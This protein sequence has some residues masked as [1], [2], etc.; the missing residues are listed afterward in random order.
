MLPVIATLVAL[1]AFAYL[2]QRVMCFVEARRFPPPGILV[3]VG[4]H[5]LHLDI[6]GK[7]GPTVVL[8]S[9]LA[10]SSLSWAEIQPRLAEVTRVVS[11]DRAGFGWSDPPLRPRR[12]DYLVEELRDALMAAGLPP[13]WVLVGH[14]Y[15][16]W[17]AQLFA[18]RYPGEVGSL[19]LVDVPH[20]RRWMTPDPAQKRRVRRGALMAKAAAL[21]AHVGLARWLFRLFARRRAGG[22]EN[23]RIRILLDKVPGHR[24]AVLRSFWVRPWTLSS[25][26]SLIEHAPESAAIVANQNRDL[27]EIPLVV[28][29]AS[30]PSADRLTEQEEIR[31]L[32]TKSLHIVAKT[33]GHWMLFDEPELVIEAVRWALAQR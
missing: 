29:T 27:D 25:L 31:K 11:Y 13:P 8:D 9:A 19:V 30:G 12:V 17:I 7:G 1:A 28:L 4:G 22:E 3:D 2:G 10:G 23:D 18:S 20:P 32:S 16:G 24:K 33:S 15:G 14:S 21:F 6:A 26:A 5:R